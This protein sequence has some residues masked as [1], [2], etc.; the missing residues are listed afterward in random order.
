M[1]VSRLDLLGAVTGD[2]DEWDAIGG[3]H[4]S[5]R[6]DQLA[7]EIDVEDRR[8]DPVVA[9][10]DHRLG[11]AVERADDRKA[12]LIQRLAKR[13]GDQRL[14]LDDHDAIA[15]DRDCPLAVSAGPPGSI[16]HCAP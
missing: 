7:A 1:S 12:Q 14:V 4:V 11:D 6:I 16:V 10:R 2:E 8:V 9:Q 15:R 13:H 5:Q 3:E